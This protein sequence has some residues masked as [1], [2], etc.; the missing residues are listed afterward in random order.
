[1]KISKS[2]VTKLCQWLENRK[3]SVLADELYSSEV[4]TEFRYLLSLQ[5]SDR[6]KSIFPSERITVYKNGEPQPSVLWHL[7]QQWKKNLQSYE[8]SGE[9]TEQTISS[10]FQQ[11]I[12]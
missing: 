3:L 10:N 12:S 4:R 5:V 2:A 11:F 9:A 7:N 8:D 6:D 1:M